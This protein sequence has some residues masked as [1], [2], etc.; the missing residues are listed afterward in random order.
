MYSI[1]DLAFTFIERFYD[2]EPSKE[3][4]L[5]IIH[6]FEKL[7]LH[8]WTLEEIQ[9]TLRAFM[10]KY[11]DD[12]PDIAKL[13]KKVDSSRQNLLKQGSFYYHNQLR[14]VPG[15][16]VRE[17]DY[18]TGEIKKIEEEFFLEMRASYTIDNVIDYYIDQLNLTPSYQERSRFIGA[19]K[20][21]LKQYNIDL[22]LFMIDQ[23]A[24]HLVYDDKSRRDY[25]PL[26]LSDY[27]GYAEQTLNHKRTE[28]KLS[29]D[30]RIV[31]RKRVFTFRGG[32]SV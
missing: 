22:L 3:E 5:A 27:R 14:I 19:L 9:R 15:A 30:D 17:L 12:R 24:N 18:N 6:E 8:G 21:L 20:Y 32:H 31:P 29:G 23:A 16:P 26:N 11:P 13:F 2:E 10:I 28:T 25:N 4:K 1:F 7:L